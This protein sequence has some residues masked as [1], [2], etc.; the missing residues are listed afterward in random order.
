MR[1]RRKN[2]PGLTTL[3]AKDNFP[4]KESNS[5]FRQDFLYIHWLSKALIS[6]NFSWGS[7]HTISVVSISM[8][9]KVKT[10]EGPTTFFELIGTPK[11]SQN[12]SIFCIS[13][14]HSALFFPTKNNRPSSG[15]EERCLWLKTK[16][17]LRNWQ[18]SWKW[19]VIIASRRAIA[20]LRNRNPQMKNTACSNP[21]DGLEG[22]WK[23]DE[24]LFLPYCILYQLNEP[25]KGH[26][27]NE[28][29]LL[30]NPI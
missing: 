1:R 26:R 4:I 2:L 9:R 8:P 30:N 5:L 14:P 16:T 22:F 7:L 25:L 15:R 18:M 17:K 12:W 6:C 28:F 10:V 29:I 13:D 11:I 23:H 3:Q 20:F 24:D 19:K 27:R 21:L